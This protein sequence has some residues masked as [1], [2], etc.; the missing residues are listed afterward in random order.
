MGITVFYLFSVFLSFKLGDDVKSIEDNV[1][2]NSIFYYDI[3]EVEIVSLKTQILNFKGKTSVIDAYFSFDNKDKLYSY[4]FV[5]DKKLI[6][7]YSIILSINEKFG[8]PIIV[9]PFNYVWDIGDS[10][11]VLSHNILRMTLKSY[12]NGE[13]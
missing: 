7:Q 3:D 1:K 13:N 5:F 11:I 8:D 10:V 4:T 6:P 2:G 9:T 12:I